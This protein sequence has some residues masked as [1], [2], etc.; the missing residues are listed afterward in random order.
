METK[1]KK[2]FVYVTNC[3]NHN[4]IYEHDNLHS[5]VEQCKY[6][7]QHNTCVLIKGTVVDWE[8]KVKK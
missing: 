5:A 8:K 3:S 7:S 6:A 1:K 2:F 4:F